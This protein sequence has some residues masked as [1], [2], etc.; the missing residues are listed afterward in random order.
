MSFKPVVRAA[1]PNRDPRRPGRLLISSLF[2]G[3]HTFQIERL[4]PDRV[5]FIQQKRFT[6]TLV[7][8]SAGSLDGGTH[9]SF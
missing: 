9:Q 1:E 7:P 2:D 5:R 8:S 3:E 6:G 4:G